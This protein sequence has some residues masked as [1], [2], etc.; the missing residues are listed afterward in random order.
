MRATAVV[1][2]NSLCQANSWVA[3][4]SAGG[5]EVRHEADGCRDLPPVSVLQLEGAQQV[6][7]LVAA[8]VWVVGLQTGCN[9]LGNIPGAYHAG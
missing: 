4:G 2:P 5:L 8:C 6:A 7:V 1:A 3:R 9:I